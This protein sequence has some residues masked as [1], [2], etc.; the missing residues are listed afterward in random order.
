MRKSRRISKECPRLWLWIHYYRLHTFII[1][2][3]LVANDYQKQHSESDDMFLFAF[4]LCSA[5]ECQ[6]LKPIDNGFID[7]WKANEDLANYTFNSVAHHYCTEGYMLFGNALR[8]CGQNGLWTG[9]EP[10]CR[11]NYSFFPS[12][13]TLYRSQH[14]EDSHQ[15]I[16][17][18]TET[19]N[20]LSTSFLKAWFVFHTSGH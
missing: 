15:F 17:N 4:G 6:A 14:R 20:A 2:G 1:Y 11:R 5:Y 8:T 10:Q 13:N 7:V 16:S 9:I 18:M 19:Y 12:Q 3:C